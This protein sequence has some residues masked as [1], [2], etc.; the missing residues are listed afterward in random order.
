MS[1]LNLSYQSI[2]V[3]RQRTFDQPLWWDLAQ[4]DGCGWGNERHMSCLTIWYTL[5]ALQG[6]FLDVPAKT[7]YVAPN[8]PKGITSLN[9]PIFTPVCLGRL[10]YEEHDTEGYRQTVKL[11]FESPVQVRAIELRTPM[12][13]PNAVSQ[14]LVDGEVC[15][16]SQ[17][18]ISDDNGYIVHIALTRELLIQHSLSIRIR[19][20]SD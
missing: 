13:I 4:N 15:E 6:F 12:R 8:L 5:F 7:V 9:T 20:P 11:S 16:R 18:I 2:H 10:K 1:L 19:E 3:P 17:E 14:I